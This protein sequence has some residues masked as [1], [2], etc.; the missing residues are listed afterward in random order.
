MMLQLPF[1]ELGKVQ[2]A[3]DFIIDGNNLINKTAIF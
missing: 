2:G 1:S 3:S